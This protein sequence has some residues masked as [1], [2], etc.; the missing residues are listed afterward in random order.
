MVAP[1]DDQPLNRRAFFSRGLA[2]A[3]ERAASAIGAAVAPP[4]Y[5]RPPGAL[6]EAAFVAACTRCGACESACPVQ[7]IV[8]LPT[9]AGL[10]AGTPAL[11]V[12]TT[13]CL[14]CADMPC[15]AACPTEALSVPETGWRGVHLARITVD[16]DRCIAFRDVACGVCAR[17]CPVG[18]DAIVLD[19]RGRPVLQPGCT[20][21]GQCI[22]ACVTSP[23]SLAAAPPTRSEP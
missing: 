6:P 22:A 16:A 8:P 3:V 2:R 20:G 5:E 17:V 10:A 12:A 11:D 15:A 1:S 9:G 7:A 18:D 23:S 13:A 19:A 4:R 21:C 14:M